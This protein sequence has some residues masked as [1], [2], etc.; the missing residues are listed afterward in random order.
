MS[1]VENSFQNKFLQ[2]SII[3]NKKYMCTMQIDTPCQK[4]NHN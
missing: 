4:K 3:N 2:E 1:P